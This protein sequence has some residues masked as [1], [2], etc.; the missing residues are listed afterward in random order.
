MPYVIL[1]K[2]KRNNE[3]LSTPTQL[4]YGEHKRKEIT[5]ILTCNRKFI[6]KIWLK[7]FTKNKGIQRK[8][9][10]KTGEKRKTK[11][12]SPLLKKI[13]QIFGRR[14]DLQKIELQI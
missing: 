11:I 5:R 6:Q 14:E 4:F 8:F 7:E 12:C 10:Q 2:T 13:V 1:D 9:V 3:S